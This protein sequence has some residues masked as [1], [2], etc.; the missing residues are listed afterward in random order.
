MTTA[1]V[2]N[3]NLMRKII[4]EMEHEGAQICDTIHMFDISVNTG[5][6]KP[7]YM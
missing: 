7:D 4:C 1:I 3:E 5:Y 6:G 2:M